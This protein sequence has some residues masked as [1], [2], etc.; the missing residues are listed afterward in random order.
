MITQRDEGDV[1]SLHPNDMVQPLLPT[2]QQPVD[3]KFRQYQTNITKTMECLASPLPVDIAVCFNATFHAP[4]QESQEVKTLLSDIDRPAN[5]DII[6]RPTNSGIYTL[7]EP[8]MYAIR[9]VDTHLHGV[10]A[11]IAKSSYVNMKLA[12]EMM[13]ANTEGHLHQKLYDD[14]LK[15][16]SNSNYA[17]FY[18][19]G[20]KMPKYVKLAPDSKFLIFSS[21]FHFFRIISSYDASNELS[22]TSQLYFLSNYTSTP[23]WPPNNCAEL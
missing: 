1:L 20:A 7:K 4:L 13:Q 16:L 23:H 6:V 11:T 21:Y 15:T 5:I 22:I 10:Q 14:G 9:S 8:A 19:F 18:C 17:K 12:E 2:P 3:N